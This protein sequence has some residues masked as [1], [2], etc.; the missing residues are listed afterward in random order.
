MQ[1]CT[2]NQN[3][4]YCQKHFAESRAVF[5]NNVE[6]Y[7]RAIKETNDNAI[8]CNHCYLPAG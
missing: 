6:E 7:G 2:E 4:F 1:N 5:L 8:R 3:T